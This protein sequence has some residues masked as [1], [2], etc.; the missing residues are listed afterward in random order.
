VK[1]DIEV[2][3]LDGTTV[4]VTARQI[5][6]VKLEKYAGAPFVKLSGANEGESSLMMDHMWH[7][8]F[9]AARRDDKGLPESYDDWCDLVDTVDPVL[10]TE[11]PAGPLAPTPTPG[12]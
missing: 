2:T 9:T 4:T 1:M 5:D 11:E 6:I 7:M 10:A 8:A 12:E 3:Y